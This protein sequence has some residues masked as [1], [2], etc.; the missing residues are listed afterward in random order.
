MGA[1]RTASYIPRMHR[2]AINHLRRADPRLA[3]VIE[4]VGGCRFTPVG[5][6]THFDA[7]VRSI[8]YQQLSGSAAG[9]I[10]QRVIGGFGGH[11][12]EPVA[13]LETP[14]ERLRGWGLSRQKIAY[15]RDLAVATC[16]GRIPTEALHTLGDDGVIAALTSVKGIGRWTAHMFLMFRLGRPDVLPELDLGVRKAM[17]RVYR[18][19]K[20][21]PPDRVHRIGAPW[22]PYRTIASWY[23]WRSLELPPAPSPSTA[24]PAV[25][26]RARKR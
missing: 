3:A 14:E 20:L 7:L 26:A 1:N 12:P 22:A 23:L 19:R 13:L 4:R 5:D 16:D 10:H 8:I 18:L 24:L 25:P 2:K 17:M 6:G 11:S 21:P 15:L 9:T